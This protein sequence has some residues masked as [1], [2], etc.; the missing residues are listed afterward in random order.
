LDLG[1]VPALDECTR[2]LDEPG[3]VI[4]SEGFDSLGIPGLDLDLGKS[5][6]DGDFGVEALTA[7]QLNMLEW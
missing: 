1:L 3:E 6:F 5:G 7:A 2:G 4:F